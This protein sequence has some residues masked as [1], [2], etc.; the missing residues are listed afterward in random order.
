MKI[1]F[2][3]IGNMGKPMAKNLLDAQHELTVYNRTRK[4]AEELADRGARIADTPADVARGT[5]L[6][7]T[8]VSDDE[9]V[10]D[11]VFGSAD[12]S[13]NEGEGLLEAMSAD[14]AHVVCSTISPDTARTLRKVHDDRNQDYVSAPVFGKPNFAEAGTLSVVAGGPDETVETCRPLFDAFGQRTFYVG[15]DPAKANIVKLVGNF[16]IAA[17]METLGESFA[18]VEKAGV[19]AEAFLD[20]INESLFDSPLYDAYGESIANRN[21]EAGFK[22]ELGLK[23]MRLAQDVAEE[24]EAP[25]PLLSL[26]HDNLLSAVAQGDGELDWSALGDIAAQRSGR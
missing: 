2:N 13:V 14:Q 11:V 15:E 16:T 21:F 18:V 10:T 9:A 3:G 20:I 8:M 6:I 25:M 5:S 24:Q 22:L 1:G 17:M 4:K 26:V 19:E 7:L 23:D 12:S